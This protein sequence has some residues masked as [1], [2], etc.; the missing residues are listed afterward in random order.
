[1]RKEFFFSLATA[2]GLLLAAAVA[3][4]QN[5][6]V[7]PHLKPLPP[8]VT[9]LHGATGPIGY[10]L[11]F[12]AVDNTLGEIVPL[13]QVWGAVQSTGVQCYKYTGTNQS[14]AVLSCDLPLCQ[15]DRIDARPC[16]LGFWLQG[17]NGWTAVET[18][19]T[20]TPTTC[21]MVPIPRAT[22]TTVPKSKPCKKKK[23]CLT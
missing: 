1:M 19:V 6:A 2:V 20:L 13:T 22:T 8:C 3:F 15:L 4:G 23:G 5:A 9:A 10:V 7:D 16:T 17:L 14:S 18:Q 21:G 12:S 11:S